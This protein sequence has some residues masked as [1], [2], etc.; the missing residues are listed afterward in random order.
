MFNR[1]ISVVFSAFGKS[2]N[3]SYWDLLPADLE[4]V[5]LTDDLKSCAIIRH[6][7]MLPGVAYLDK[8]AVSKEERGNFNI[9]ILWQQLK[10]DY[11]SL[12]W[13]S[14]HNNIFNSW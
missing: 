8:F 7:P 3:K 9:E 14:R 5:Y 12:F 13:R 11:K 6:L 4:S 2:T 10:H 1:I